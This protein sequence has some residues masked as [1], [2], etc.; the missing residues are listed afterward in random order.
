MS[1][2]VKRNV[3]TW[4]VRKWSKKPES[5]MK[6]ELACPKCLIDAEIEIGPTPGGLIIAAIGLGLVFD[7]PG[8]EPPK[9]FMPEEIR[10]RHCRTIW[11]SRRVEP[12]TENSSQAPSPDQ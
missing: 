3:K 8:Y 9:N 1:T 6:Y 2:R 7:P 5:T 4:D 12:C 10:C 11:S